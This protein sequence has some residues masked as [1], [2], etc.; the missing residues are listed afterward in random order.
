[1]CWTKAATVRLDR[2]R[3]P[4]PIIGID[5]VEQFVVV[6]CGSNS[7]YVYDLLSR[8]Y[9]AT[10][11]F[12]D[13]WS[14]R[15]LVAEKAPSGIRIKFVVSNKLSNDDLDSWLHETIF[16][17][18]LKGRI[19]LDQ[20]TTKRT[21]RIVNEPVQTICRSSTPEVYLVTHRCSYGMLRNNVVSWKT[22]RNVEDID[23]DGITFIWTTGYQVDTHKFRSR[24][25]R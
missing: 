10:L 23:I 8:S 20:F 17:P 3:I 25:F 22:I 7:I 21:V 11:L 18:S 2:L 4:G 5:V 13:G 1:M 14:I 9:Q 6:S 12:Q 16:F 19:V 24:R 15:S